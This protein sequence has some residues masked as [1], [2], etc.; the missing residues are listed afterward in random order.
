MRGRHR[1]RRLPRPELPVWAG[2]PVRL[3][4]FPGVAAA[5]VGAAV[6]AAMTLGV[7]PVLLASGGSAALRTRLESLSGPP[8]ALSASVTLAFGPGAA[9][10]RRQ[11]LADAVGR[12][13]L[14]PPTITMID[15]GQTE[16]SGGNHPGRTGTVQ[17][18]ARGGFEGHVHRFEGA[19]GA[20]VWLPASVARD[21]GVH[22]GDR[23]RVTLSGTSA[24]ARVAAVYRDLAPARIPDF[25]AALASHIAVDPASPPPPPFL[26][27]GLGQFE[28]LAGRLGSTGTLSIE[29]PIAGTLPLPQA[30]RVAAELQRIAADAADPTSP[31]SGA[32]D[33]VGSNLQALVA[34]AEQTHDGTSQPVRTISLAGGLL[35][36]VAAGVTGQFMARRRH[37]EYA[38]LASRGVGPVRLALRTAVEAVLPAAA[39]AAAGWVA[40]LALVRLLGPGG[41]V[42]SDATRSSAIAVVVATATALAVLAAVTGS[43]ARAEGGDRPLWLRGVVARTPWEAAALALALASLYEIVTRGAVPAA[44]ATGRPHVDLLILLFPFL[45]LAGTAGLVV[46]TGRRLLPRLKAFGRRRS[47]WAFIAMA[48]LDSAPRL[49][50]LLVTSSALSIGILAYAAVLSSSIAATATEKA[51]LSI[52]SDVAVTVGSPPV[53]PG[54]P[55]FGWTPIERVLTV[56]VGPGSGQAQLLLVDRQTFARGAFWDSR[57]DGS[58][59]NLMA[60]LRGEGKILPVVVVGGAVPSDARLQVGGTETPLAAVRTV[61]YFPGA[62]AGRM[63]LVADRA[64]VS[65][66]V[67]VDLHGVGH[68]FQLWAKGDPARIVPALARIGF[69]TS[70]ASTVAGVRATPAFLA[71]SWTFG[72]LQA[73]GVL[74]G[75]VAALG[76]VLYLQARQRSREVSYVLA[77]RMGLRRDAHRRS[78]LLELA[79]MLVAAFVLGTSFAILAAALVHGRLDPIPNLPPGPLLHVPL[80]VLAI[81]AAATAV[82]AV[83]GA[84]RVQGLAD[85][86]EVG[87]VMRLA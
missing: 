77:R 33:S 65:R 29:Y 12:L 84:W 64:A 74:A 4:R 71:L 62:P 66:T 28:D 85:R 87:E 36:L 24:E 43:A 8:I 37:A 6:I 34:I 1:R 60:R 72:L 14:G 23:I 22:A 16:V 18:V 54:H 7:A 40:A 61:R 10:L 17:L 56:G 59:G 3:L 30:S 27:A 47:P 19:D 49:A 70:F 51:S 15:S 25:W 46:R 86:A 80:G 2:T 11:I 41:A 81:A 76:T 73:L 21:L 32:F 35:A 68:S 20:G 9:S 31:L 75:A 79:T 39:G 5:V 52:G 44:D 45:F 48:R 57:L 38:L 26:L 83:A 58:V 50:T 55:G 67:P 69:P 78:I 42:G 82:A 53:V 13:P 63:T